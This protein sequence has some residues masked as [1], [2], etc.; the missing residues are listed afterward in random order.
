MLKLVRSM[1]S[2]VVRRFR[3]RAVV[4][5]QNL[6][7]RHQLIGALFA[8]SH[9]CSWPQR[10]AVMRLRDAWRVLQVHWRILLVTPTISSTMLFP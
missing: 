6:A 8:S 5:L 3:S 9:Y 10:I 2:V 1:V 4:E 7:L